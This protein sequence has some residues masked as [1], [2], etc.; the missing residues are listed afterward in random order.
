MTLI[1]Q[2]CYIFIHDVRHKDLLEELV[3]VFDGGTVNLHHWFLQCLGKASTEFS[4][5]RTLRAIH[6][7]ERNASVRGLT[8]QI[9]TKLSFDVILPNEIREVFHCSVVYS[10]RE[11]R[12]SAAGCQAFSSGAYSSK[13]VMLKEIL[14]SGSSDSTMFLTRFTFCSML[15]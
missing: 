13:F 9:K 2:N 8:I 7:D 3:R 15:M 1:K 4:L 5:A 6:H 10:G 12:R 14:L 11:C